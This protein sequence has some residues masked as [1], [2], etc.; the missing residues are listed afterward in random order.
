M[1]KLKVLAAAAAFLCGI[2]IGSVPLYAAQVE[3][4]VASA[5]K[6]M[7]RQGEMVSVTVGLSDYTD[8][9]DGINAVRGTL[10]Y[11][12][13]AFQEVS[14]ED[15]T[16]VNEWESLRY[17]SD[18]CQFTAVKRSGTTEAED[19]LTI[20]FMAKENIAAGDARIAV[21]N[22]EISEGKEDLY[23]AD[24]EVSVAIVAQEPQ[25]G[26]PVAPDNVS[27]D[28]T[29][30]GSGK[31]QDSATRIPLTGDWFVPAVLL[32]VAGG[33]A[34][35]ACFIYR[36]RRSRKF[37]HI[38]LMTGAAVVGALVFTA[39]AGAYAFGGR[40]DLNGDGSIDYVDVRLLQDHLIDLNLL[41]E[42]KWSIADMNSDGKLTVTDLSLLIQAAEDRVDYQVELISETENFY[43]K[44]NEE[45]EL[46]FSANVV[47]EAEIESV[48]VDGKELAVER[49]Q[50]SS[51]YTVKVNAGEEAGVRD[52]KITEVVLLGGRRVYTDYTETVDVLKT[53]P[54]IT[55][56]HVEESGTSEDVKV[57]FDLSDG[58]SAVTSGTVGLSERAE[59]GDYPVG[60]WDLKAGQNTL[61][62][63]L[64]E[65]KLYVLDF[66]AEYDLDSGK[67]SAHEEDHSGS[68]ELEKEIRLNL[69]YQF[70]FS[71]LRTYGEDLTET[72]IFGKNQPVVV[73]FDSFNATKYVPVQAVINGDTYQVTGEGGRY[74]VQLNGFDQSGEK[75]IKLEQII[76]DNGKVFT[77]TDNNVVTIRVEKEQPEIFDVKIAEN[78]ENSEIQISFAIKDPDGVLSQKQIVILN[79][80]GEKITSQIFEDDQFDE[81][82]KI[83]NDLYKKYTV[84]IIADYDISG[85]GEDVQSGKV[86][87]EKEI[88]ALARVRVI[89]SA[90][91]DEF[92]E[93]GDTVKISYTIESNMESAIEKLVINN[94]EVPVS[95]TGGNVY[96][97]EMMA[98][99]SA[100]RTKITLSQVVFG[101]GTTVNAKV[102]DEIE[103][104]RS[105]PSVENAV[106]EDD[107]DNSQV[108]LTFELTDTDKAFVSGRVELLKDGTV[109][110]KY[111][112]DKAGK[113]TVDFEVTEDEEYEVKVIVT[114][115]RSEKGGH[116]V[117]DQ[118]L[119]TM[120]ICLIHDYGLS[121]GDIQTL[122][123][124]GA[125]AIYFEK[126]A[127]IA[128][129]L[130][131]K[132]NTR[133][134]ASAIQVNG[135]KYG[136]TEA[137]NNR[138]TFTAKGYDKSGVQTLT[139]EKIWMSNG[140]ELNVEDTKESKIEVLKDVPS[141][142]EFTSEQTDR[143]KLKVSFILSDDESALSEA[144][145]V[146]TDENGSRLLEKEIN[147][148]LN[149]AEVEL[150]S[151]LSYQAEVTVSY[152]RDTNALG[153][154][155]NR[156]E[157]QEIFSKEL[158][159]SVDVIEFKDIVST[160]LYRGT[161]EGAAEKV[162]AIDI[163]KGV[164]TDVDSYY[165]VIEMEDLPD[166]Y[167]SVKEFR[168]TEG[169]SDVV[170]V[171]DQQEIIQ[172]D[173]DA[174]ARKNE[175]SFTVTGAGGE[176]QPDEAAEFFNKMSSN[177]TG[178]FQLNK[179]LDASRLSDAEAAVLGT[180]SG[181]LDGNGHRIYNLNRPLF[182]TLQG[183]KIHD[184]VIED[185]NITK[186]V[187]GILANNI[188]GGSKITNTYI[189]NSSLD[190][191]QNQIGGF[192]GI[193]D[194][195]TI[196]SCALVDV[197]IKGRDTIGGIGGQLNGS[198]TITDCYVTG[199]LIGTSTSSSSGARV[200]GITGWH[201]GSAIER[202][203]TKVDITAPSRTGNGG[204]IGGPQGYDVVI[205]N[206]LSMSIGDAYRIAGFDTLDIAKSVYEY[207]GSDSA[208]N[209]KDTNTVEETSD[210]YSKDFY[211]DKLGFSE[212]TWNFDLIENGIIPSLQGDPVPKTL[213][214][215][216]LE[217]NA[218]GI[219][220]YAEV[221]KNKAYDKS[222]EVA[223]AN[224]AKLMPYADTALWVKTGNNLD[225]AD[226]L[227][228]KKI[229][230]VL[231]LGTDNS[232]VSAVS[233][234]NETAV[235]KIRI[236]YEDHLN[237]EISVQYKKQVGSIV[238]LYESSERGVDYQFGN[239][240]MKLD[241]S[242]L[243]EV[244]SLAE[245]YDYASVLGALTT[246]NESRLYT[247]Y[248]NEQV[249]PALG[250]T[251]VKWIG[252]GEEFPT[253]CS[254]QTV[255]AQVRQ[256]LKNESRLKDFL[257]AFNYYDKWY[258]IDFDGVT[259]SDL[260][261][262]NGTVLADKM[263]S[264]YLTNQ[265]LRAGESLR[266]VGKTQNFY[267][268]VL[269]GLTGKSMMD[270]LGEMSK[271]VAGYDNP[272]DWMKDEFDGILVEQ[273]CY[274]SSGTT[275]YRIWDI[276]NGL[277]DRRNIVLPILTAPQEDMYLI[278]VPS[279]LM[280][281][282]LNRYSVYHETNGRETMRQRMES[283]AE[284]LGRF[285]GVSANLISGAENRLNNIVNIQYDTRFYF[286]QH[287]NIAAGTQDSGSTNDPVI[288]W[289][290]E[291]VNSFA[292]GNGSGAYANGTNVWWVVYALLD[293]TAMTTITHETAHN[294][295]SS[296][297]YAGNG[298]RYYTGAESHADG[299][300]AQQFSDGSMVFNMI[301]DLDITRG[302]TN[303]FSYKR[304]DTEDEIHDY[305]KDMFETGYVL[306]YLSGQAFLQL[307]P[308]QQAAVASQ[309]NFNSSGTSLATAHSKLSAEEFEKMDLKDMEDLWDN[310][311]VIKD[312]TG[313]PSASSGAYGYESFYDSNWYL[314][315]NDKGSPTAHGFKRLGQEMLGVAG[316]MDGYV[317]YMSG[318]SSNDLDALRKITGDPN[319]TWKSYKMD[320]YKTVEENLD[321]IPY[322]DS[323]EVIEQFKEAF[324]KDAQIN[325][326]TNVN[327]VK[328]VL[329][330][331]IKRATNDFTDGTVYE[332]PKQI[333]I[334][335]AQQLID[336]AEQN[337]FGNYRLEA[338]IDFSGIEDKNGAYIT[339]RFMGILDGNGYKMVGM[340][341]T[342]FRE[343]LYAQIKNLKIETPSYDDSA[344]SILVGTSRN[345][346]VR[347]ITVDQA[348]IRLPLVS[349]RNNEYYEYGKIDITV[350]AV[351]IDTAEEFLKIGETSS[352]LKKK[353]VLG[354]DLDFKDVEVPDIAISGT[355]SGELD[356]NGHT[357]SN[358]NS[359]LFNQMSQATIKNLGIMG[360]G[361]LDGNTQKG[362]LANRID[363]SVV[364]KVYL[365]N[366]NITNN[367]SQV[368][369][370]AGI[371]EGSTVKEVSLENIHVKG[372]DTVGGLAGQI[373]DSAVSDC[374]V[375]GQITATYN[376]TI[377]G[378]RAGG[379]TGWLSPSSTLNNCYSKV[380]ITSPRE[381][382]S[383]GLVAGPNNTAVNI[384]NSLSMS[385]GIAHRIAG[386]DTLSGSSNVYEYEKSNSKTNI[387]EANKDRVK[388]A[389]DEQVK[390]QSFYTTELN[391]S[392]EIWDLSGV[393]TG[394]TPRL[395][396]A[397]IDPG[398]DY[399]SAEA[400]QAAS[401]EEPSTEEEVHD[402]EVQNETPT[403][404]DNVQKNTLPEEDV[405]QEKEPSEKG[406]DSE[407]I[408]SGE[409]SAE[410]A[411][412][413]GRE[414]LKDTIS[415]RGD[416]MGVSSIVNMDVPNQFNAVMKQF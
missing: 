232:L 332:A 165:A 255:K 21:T 128:A 411:E 229:R 328:S 44:K 365:G 406:S 159:A 99:E 268:S 347:D 277:G 359:V 62:L 67:L 127:D 186:Q 346:A 291:A 120:P 413:S 139:P 97:A 113:S 100:G 297:F 56:F 263:T 342:L 237:E 83:P 271:G 59:G 349:I 32:I 304:I 231:P 72:A 154:D 112:I 196:S 173:S 251:I 180:F 20:H 98:P 357:I 151:S 363:N 301:S 361:T 43:P 270:F 125:P 143:S 3:N 167:A 219:P 369:G 153:N 289:V 91:S 318:K 344:A 324:I 265:V 155:S 311:I 310:R 353:Y 309:V 384:T 12:E 207:A 108:H 130:D 179:D 281:G 331:I 414:I 152:D 35:T 379:I 366:L 38:K 244:V 160:Q 163:S 315:H 319:I 132:T 114:Y 34:F 131:V 22:L 294:Q 412:P 121:A 119:L 336:L 166:F 338:D 133:L 217:V 256:A 156:F 305:Y 182:Q 93:K 92:V 316:Y 343:A 222:R 295:D 284:K 381:L 141:V 5:D 333:G 11:D 194:S 407:N 145:L 78:P 90:L 169:S 356:G 209:V 350:R 362:L 198:T 372:N 85:T 13:S 225:A 49:E 248:Y 236:V 234:K 341:H 250:E 210:I 31:Q 306:E 203:F 358:L 149:E 89:G 320:R 197:S 212:T 374:M 213:D 258:N 189:I 124:S 168:E 37:R 87:Y 214:E 117:A 243:N 389:G 30:D 27:G 81:A 220:N 24:S 33:A 307:E 10:E 9:A 226:T 410:K 329:Y 184:L 272:S 183:A 408:T 313:Q 390:A 249:K 144:S 403:N 68:L 260:M 380:N 208:S 267:N 280:I 375:T 17:N 399:I 116:T 246:E 299:N 339:N 223:Y 61:E 326:R 287:G 345:F 47:P 126:G 240:I 405:V 158:T 2:A 192:S 23:P 148:G 6:D 211:V 364:E 224:M 147:A 118:M 286:P 330:G 367:A 46:K 278:S 325:K 323:D 242:L 228:S 42:D 201:S 88:D 171:I 134:T 303:N 73:Q 397:L 355:F 103:V 185:A 283:I 123:A 80:K 70:E 106:V 77:L 200:G 40:G 129:A 64:E 74:S 140:K 45:T 82:V 41:P 76:L 187:K 388:V 377:L 14:L 221:R 273:D 245:S 368:G 25:P 241:E 282:S 257:Y 360:A 404:E 142:K 157:D 392:E 51:V 16:T 39:A 334:T 79:D 312:G 378:G 193:I 261:F 199:T 53:Q 176:T 96:Q 321:K 373:T 290:Y 1:K 371:I 19:I 252:S 8:I 26:T 215:Y 335:S 302:W 18:N 50:S 393:A 122:S 66:Y 292:A 317:T 177:S 95:M 322:F 65:D 150:T 54:S 352:G 101:N 400:E 36:S 376:N 170:V 385:T 57:I 351:T 164:P 382:G 235:Q 188:S 416:P 285:Y 162:D 298:R 218:N 161:G 58:D 370:M 348:D 181:E 110:Q 94:I 135:Q 395:K 7:I 386:F 111:G 136:L 233:D 4:S 276:L 227:L 300:I 206:S 107:F 266:N 202:C 327:N 109:Q 29:F 230:F 415:L 337:V 409:T 60:G 262:F 288:K 296:Y 63:T 264:D 102:T 190:N 175:F 253:Y 172:Y 279:Q 84:Q 69:D 402:K 239:Y 205:N 275:R 146:I 354:N 293:D 115:E 340:N 75:E 178:S 269:Q 401:Q 55:N 398:K 204:I 86:I 174:V 138:Y 195:S 387:T 247:D 216:E 52:F 259:L 308:E 254:Q 105:A 191:S 383:G 48:V 28:N 396:R 15:I 391:W 274:Q 238:A 314:I 394:G 71:D 137:G 104:L